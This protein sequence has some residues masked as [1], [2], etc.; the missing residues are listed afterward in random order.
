MKEDVFFVQKLA[1]DRYA[2]LKYYAR[3]GQHEL[4][5]SF[6]S[7]EDAEEFCHYMNGGTPREWMTAGQKRLY[8]WTL[9]RRYN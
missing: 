6:D 7:V 1:D 2:V 3:T 5:R 8:E 4:W 9:V